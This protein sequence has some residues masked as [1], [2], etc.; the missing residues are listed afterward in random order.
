MS[1]RDP[2]VLGLTMKE[3]KSLHLL[4]CKCGHE[5]FGHFSGGTRRCSYCGCSTLRPDG[6]SIGT[7]VDVGTV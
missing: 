7:P 5:E 6:F 1:E 2:I 3:A 4:V